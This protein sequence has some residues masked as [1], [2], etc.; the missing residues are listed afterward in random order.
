MLQHQDCP[1][2]TCDT[3]EL[4]KTQAWMLWLC[5]IQRAAPTLPSGTGV[6]S[7]PLRG[8]IL[9]FSKA[10]LP[11]GKMQLQF[12]TLRNPPVTWTLRC[13]WEPRRVCGRQALRG[14]ASPLHARSRSRRSQYTHLHLKHCQDR[15]SCQKLEHRMD[16]RTDKQWRINI[17]VTGLLSWSL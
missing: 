13:C 16:Q 6:V 2:R 14:R 4:H 17:L 3:L 9:I 5:V 1:R 11:L 10:P 8:W 15:E 12:E 7:P